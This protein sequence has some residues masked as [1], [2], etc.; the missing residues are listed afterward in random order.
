MENGDGGPGE[1]QVG[2]LSDFYWIV[3]MIH[4]SRWWCR[5]VEILILGS[6]GCNPIPRATCQ[7]RVCVE[8]RE[9]GVPYSRSGVAILLEDINALFD[10]P[11]EINVQLNREN[12][13]E[14]DYLF[15]THWHPDHVRGI[16][17]LEQ[18]RLHWLLL[19]LEGKKSD[20]PVKVL[21]RKDVLDDLRA[22]QNKHGS[23]IGHYE[24]M[25]T[26]VVSAMIDNEPLEID[27][28]RIT[29][30]PSATVQSPSTLFVLEESD[31]KIIYAPCDIKPILVDNPILHNADLLIMGDTM[32][33]EPLKGNYYVPDD[34]PL[35]EE[36]YT[37]EQVA[38]L[39]NQIQADRVLITHIEEEYGKSYDDCLELEERFRSDRISFAYDGMRLKFQKKS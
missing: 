15:Y 2:R 23:L 12:V 29:A 14:I 27:G 26:A 6:G 16:R 7:C 25:N 38:E 39:R 30:V 35:R 18:L 3:L 32:P 10:T 1:I 22:I 37:L 5:E 36:V 33:P 34:N 24:R 17:L 21:A 19:Y 8:A 20:N 13:A 11:E 9:K 4:Q 31:T 28:I